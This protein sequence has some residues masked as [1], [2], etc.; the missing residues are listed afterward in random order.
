[1]NVYENFDDIPSMTLK[2]TKCYRQTHTHRDG[3]REK[4]IPT[5]K[6]SLGGYNEAV[7]TSIP[8]LYVSRKNSGNVKK[9]YSKIVIFTV[10]VVFNLHTYIDMLKKWI[11]YF[12]A[13]LFTLENNNE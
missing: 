2:E 3:H 13:E 7:L 11:D 8:I 12:H 1:M 5:N 4:S 9:F 6:H 10:T